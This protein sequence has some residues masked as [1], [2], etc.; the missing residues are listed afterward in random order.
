MEGYSFPINSDWST[1]EIV[2]VV[3]F[4]SKVEEAYLEG[5]R[6]KDFQTAYLAF[7]QIVTSKSEEKQ[8]DRNYT[9]ESGYSIYQVVKVMKDLLSQKAHS[10]TVIKL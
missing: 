1:E 5:I 8:I 10:S 3:N 2:I 9:Q 4:L 6:L 7:K